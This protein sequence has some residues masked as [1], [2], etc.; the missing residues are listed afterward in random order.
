M[1]DMINVRFHCQVSKFSLLSMEING[2]LGLVSVIISPFAVKIIWTAA[3]YKMSNWKVIGAGRKRGGARFMEIQRKQ[4]VSAE[5]DKIENLLLLLGSLISD[6]VLLSPSLSSPL[7]LNC[8]SLWL[9]NWIENTQ[10]SLISR[11]IS[12]AEISESGQK[13]VSERDNL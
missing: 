13:L 4:I 10:I 1:K 2:H 6:S 5:E 9:Y 7:S 8:I 3:N 11:L 12:N